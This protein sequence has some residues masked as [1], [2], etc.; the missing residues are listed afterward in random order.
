MQWTEQQWEAITARGENLLVAA[1]AGSGKTAVLVERIIRRITDKEQPV[2]V[3]RLLVLTFTEAAAGEMKRKIA[4]A[5]EAAR[6]AAP[7]DRWLA[8]QCML[9]HS[10]QIS[11]IHAFCKTILQ[12]YIHKTD[13]PADFSII[14][15][16]ENEVLRRRALDAVMESY[17]RRIEKKTGFREL[18]L[19]Y[20][21]IKNDDRLR[22]MILRLDRFVRSLP[23]PK[24][25]LRESAAAYRRIEKDRTLTGTLWE[26]AM[27][28][29]AEEELAD[30]KAALFEIC[31]IVDAEVP[32]DHKYAAFF[33]ALYSDFCRVFEEMPVSIEGCRKQLEA[34]VI[35]RVPVKKGLDERVAE[36]IAALRTDVVKKQLDGLRSLFAEN[37]GAERLAK[38]TPAMLA[39]KQIL[40]QTQRLHTRYK[41]ERSAL[42]FNDME[43]ETMKLLGTMEKP[44]A[45]LMALREKYIEILVDEY[46]DTNHLQDTMFALLSGGQNN[47]FM[48]G[49]L[50]Q[51]IYGFRNAD[52]SIFAEKYRAYGRGDGGRLIRLFRNFR[53]RKEVVDAVNSVF[54]KIMSPDC[55][56]VSYTE[57]EFLI[58][59]AQYPPSSGCETELLLT[60]DETREGSPEETEAR[61]VAERIRGLMRDGFQVTDKQTGEQRPLRFGDITILMRRA[62]G[63]AEVFEQTFR[64][65]GIPVYTDVGEEYLNSVEVKTV[66]CFLQIIDN[67]LQDIPLLAVM[68]SPIFG[69]TA[70]ELAE[71]RTCAKGRYYD[72]VCLAAEKDKKAAGFLHVLQEL[73]RRAAYT[74]IDGLIWYI[75]SDL[76]YSAMVGAMPGGA[77]RRANLKLLFEHGA[78]F[79]NGTLSGVF[80]FMQ[81]IENIKSGNGD[82]T[83]AKPYA[84]GADV[85]RIMTVHKSKGL[86]FPVV[87]LCGMHTAYNTADLRLPVLWHVQQGLAFDWMDGEARRK[88][89]TPAHT[90]AS[91]Q[92]EKELRSEELR[93]LYVAMTRAS[94]KLILSC[95]YA[96][97]KRGADQWQKA[98][99]DREGRVYPFAVKQGKRFMDW[100][101]PAYLSHPAGGPLRQLAER[102]DLL[103]AAEESS[104]RLLLS[105]VQTE[106]VL[107]GREEPEE[108]GELPGDI[109][110]RF[111]YVYPHK[112]LSGTPVKLSVSEMKRRQMPEGEYTP[113]LRGAS[114]AILTDITEIG[115]AEK[116]TITHFCLQQIEPAG[117][118]SLAQVSGQ[119]DDLVRRGVLQQRQ[120][121]AVA[122]GDLYAFY[123]SPLGQRIRK[124]K[125][126]Y[127]EF[128]FYLTVPAREVQGA[129]NFPEEDGEELVLLQGIA[130]CF[131]IEDGGIVLVDYK[132]DKTTETMAETAAEK[133]RIQL[134]YYARGIAET[135]GI[136]VKERYVYFLSC[137]KAVSV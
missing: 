26:K 132:T 135:M 33:P 20:G 1:A 90:L 44:S 121:E 104:F 98:V 51:S 136:P 80:D 35:P 84:D 102:E 79:E 67:P 91:R 31:R 126:V 3:D 100:I 124:A 108:T 86:E 7:E 127:R 50:K 59:G 107:P 21:G 10:A 23:Y 123:Q 120:R 75:I 113:R 61:Q 54:S 11:T 94:E 93:L 14:D 65:C 122:D 56:D 130:D 27:L 115:A 29:F 82:L 96:P 60:L 110:K 97:G 111:S 72:A 48:V 45:P 6:R 55:G 64:L 101:L 129:E 46:Q 85:V 114:Q 76:K 134:A 81:Y 49:D 32:A 103:P 116:G 2:D 41:R 69:F 109:L 37:D 28:S 133:Y 43:H 74:G 53:S 87:F 12:N 99:F 83:P 92:K 117:T 17:Y 36:R 118:E 73:R 19:G 71:I 70:E 18:V 15:E 78:A 40:R 128:D 47:L 16:T 131:F 5:L 9:V 39:L 8:K 52:P 95:Y 30:I 25:W 34:F 22:D 106:E 112:Q 38:C 105:N 119:L 125:D 13:L 58:Q 4:D 77:L 137:H 24:R 66:L 62:K 88:Y 42:D 68:R 57:E 63:M 89:K